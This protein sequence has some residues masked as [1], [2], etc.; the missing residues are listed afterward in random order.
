L[1]LARGKNQQALG[2]TTFERN[3]EGGSEKN[4]DLKLHYYQS[5]RHSK[6][7]NNHIEVP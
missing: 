1:G 5:N 4:V 3:L 6:S 7:W 2:V